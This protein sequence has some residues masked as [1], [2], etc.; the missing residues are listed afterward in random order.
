L[1]HSGIELPLEA[2]G[3]LPTRAWKRQTQGEAVVD[4]DDYNLGIGQGS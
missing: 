1:P 3:N 4:G 2:E